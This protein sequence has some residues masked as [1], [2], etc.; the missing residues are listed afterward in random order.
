MTS[1]LDTE[2][3]VRRELLHLALRNSTRSV[4]LQLIAVAVVV[5]FGIEAGTVWAP[6]AAALIGVVVAV[7]RYSL[8]RR[9][10]TEG[11]LAEERVAQATWELEGNSI[12]A[13]LLWVVCSLGIYPLL[14]GTRATTY[15]V[16]AIGS[17]ATAAL[18]MSL[19]G[20]S[21]NWLVGLSMG[22]VVAA[23]LLVDNVRSWPLAILIAIFGLTMVRASREVS[24]TTSRAIRHGL[25][26]DLANASL[27][28]AKDAAEAAN[29]AKSQFLATMSHEIRTPMNGVLGSLD[30][31]RHSELDARQRHLVNT[32]VVSGSSL[33][34]ILND[35]LDHSKIEAGKLNLANAS[36]ALHGLS[37]SVIA[38]FRANA[39]G[40][41]LSLELE[42]DRRVANWVIGDAQRLKQ[43]LLN[44]LGNAIKFTE[45]GRVSLR[46]S[47]E[48]AP[49]G[50]A[51]VRFEVRDTGVG[52]P[53]DAIG[54][55]FQPF[56]QVLAPDK[57][58]A[59]GTGLGLA[60]SQRIVEAMGSRIE[61]ESSPGLG[62]R[63]WFSATFEVDPSETHP[64][65]LDS[66]MGG[67]D[68]EV[69]IEGTALVVED[70][71]VNRMI[72]REVL[73]S[74]GMRVH[75]ASNGVEAL[76][77]MDTRTFDIVLMDCFMPVLDGYATAREI[78]RREVAG[79][80]SRM[81]IIA[82]TANAFEEDAQQA[83]AAGMD[84]H[85]AKPYTRSQLRDLLKT[86]L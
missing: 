8:S 4:P 39:E 49:F 80:R 6:F 31:L 45:R 43:V 7:W 41:G 37:T 62:S 65:P 38:L 60:I 66:S 27:L 75:E 14:N 78:R 68:G 63:F 16:I 84:A 81:P 85:L 36:M 64:V 3:A 22:S 54:R 34:E 25:E 82:V 44:L 61:V 76:D 29:M 73:Q 50:K 15:V 77:A 69:T 13:G 56:H 30:L 17:V 9:Y 21:F 26:E 32:A 53:P 1:R 86:W 20:R 46:L 51:R 33:M 28:Q 18:F 35:V 58:R 83:H 10:G 72:A 74:L 23:S 70:N 5:A 52:I 48:D 19:V 2:V 79:S 55:L 24:N 57:R 67:L 11:V 12:L 59:G 47:P 42:L 40:K 71:D